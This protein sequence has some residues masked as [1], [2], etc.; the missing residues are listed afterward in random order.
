M[1][2]SIGAEHNYCHFYHSFNTLKCMSCHCYLLAIALTSCMLYISDSH[3]STLQYVS[4]T[5]VSILYFYFIK[6]T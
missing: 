3:A 5:V 1:L 2:V 6:V 4:I